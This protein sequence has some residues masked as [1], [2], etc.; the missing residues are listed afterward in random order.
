MPESASGGIC[1]TSV[2]IDRLESD[3][4]RSEGLY[5][6]VC[7]LQ[8]SCAIGNCILGQRVGKLDL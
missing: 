5:M 3:P 6:H 2:E 8:G 4:H 1:E 7:D